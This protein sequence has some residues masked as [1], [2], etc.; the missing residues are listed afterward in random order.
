MRILLAVLLALT[1]SVGTVSAA[2][3]YFDG[4][5]IDM[6]EDP[7]EREKVLGFIEEFGPPPAPPTLPVLHTPTTTHTSSNPE[8]SSAPSVPKYI[9]NPLTDTFLF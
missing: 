7:V 3:E 4:V 2:V 8:F 5:P 6:P 1:F 9:F